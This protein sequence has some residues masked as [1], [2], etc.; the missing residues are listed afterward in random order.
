MIGWALINRSIWALVGGAICSSLATMLL[1]HF[2]LPGIDN[3]WYW[4][5]SAFHEIIHFGKW[6]LLSAILGFFANNADRILLGVFVDSATLGIYSIAVTIVSSIM[7][8]LSTLVSEVSFPAFSELARERPGDLKSSLYRF[9]VATASFTYFCSGFL[10]MFGSALMRVL[11]D[12]RYEQAGWMVQVLAVGL[13]GVSFNLAHNC[14]LARGLPK[15]FTNVIAIRVGVTIALI[16]LGFHYFGLLGALWAI[17]ISQLSSSPVTL[18]YQLRYDLFDF[19]KELLPVPTLFVGMIF[20]K[21]LSLAI[22]H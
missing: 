10:I 22:G 2:W 18:Y 4:D 12:P 11:Y 5:R 3:R 8:I 9:H 19:S 21:G 6:M 1:S 15:V 17:V 14:L 7:Q 16:P 20:G 13:L